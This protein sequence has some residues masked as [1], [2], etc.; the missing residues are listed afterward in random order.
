MEAQWDSRRGA[1]PPLPNPLPRGEDA[2]E[3]AEIPERPRAF[4]PGGALLDLAERLSSTRLAL[5][6]LAV[7]LICAGIYWLVGLLGHPSLVER[8]QPVRSLADAIYFSLVTATSVGYGDLLPVGA[9]RAVAVAEA[10]AGLLI[11]GALIAKFVSRRQD[12]LVGEIHRIARE[13]RLDRVQ[14]N[15]HMLV[16]EFQSLA[17]TPEGTDVSPE[18][19]V[20]RL[21]GGVLL[22]AG[23][24]RTVR[25]LLSREQSQIDAPTL[26]ALLVSLVSSLTAL[27]ASLRRMGSSTPD[28]AVLADALHAVSN[29]ASTF[30]TECV[31]R[32]YSA[33]L[34]VWVDRVHETAAKL[35]RLVQHDGPAV[36][37]SRLSSPTGR[38][39]S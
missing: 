17:A 5:I 4:R 27:D 18:Q 2:R 14:T 19:V 25:S 26:K 7:I 6:W 12:E 15:L 33:D 21:E 37:G 32:V 8:N 3:R 9:V 1:E 28:S 20:T 22:L 34:A 30:C 13:Q 10:V 23:E 24:L 35:Q 36:S 29:L 39:D 38:P 16:A 31:R 11:F